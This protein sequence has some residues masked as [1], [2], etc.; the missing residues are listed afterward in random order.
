MRHQQNQTTKR[1]G[2][3][4][5]NATFTFTW[6]VPIQLH[7]IHS[8]HHHPDCALTWPNKVMYNRW[9]R[10][11][12]CITFIGHSH[13]TSSVL[14]NVFHFPWK[15]T[16]KF[17]FRRQQWVVFII[18][19]P[20]PHVQCSRSVLKPIRANRTVSLNFHCCFNANK[21]DLLIIVSDWISVLTDW[22]WHCYESTRGVDDF[23]MASPAS[24]CMIWGSHHT[25]IT[26][27]YPN[28]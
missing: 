23:P 28:C 8:T 13:S 16:S 17:L 14:N 22:P 11:Y 25:V 5:L 18:S 7:F 1:H 12:T 9:L 6:S 19:F 4:T 2:I 26:C 27:C 24:S 20:R 3:L 10:D 15:I 21:T